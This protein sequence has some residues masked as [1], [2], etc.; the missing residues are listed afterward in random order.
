MIKIESNEKKFRLDKEVIFLT[1]SDDPVA[2]LRHHKLEIE[3]ERYKKAGAK[4][5]SQVIPGSRHDI[6][7]DECKRIVYGYIQNYLL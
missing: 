6:L 1:G 2:D 4:V 3:E 5:L 7:H